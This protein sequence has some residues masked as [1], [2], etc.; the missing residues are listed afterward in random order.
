MNLKLYY[1]DEEIFNYNIVSDVID[2]SKL[3]I[4]NNKYIISSISKVSDL[5]SKLNSKYIITVTDKDN[6][7]LTDNDYLKTNC[8]I[9]I[10][11]SNTN[12]EYI[13]VVMGDV[14]GSGNIFIGDISKLY[15]YYKGLITLEES[16]KIAGDVTY[17]GVIE[18]N[19]ISK[20]Y[21]Y[22]KGIIKTLE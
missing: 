18:I 7:I 21:Q 13:I 6:N 15:R 12:Y 5:K 2:L 19:D 3:N 11:L 20:L 1:N 8:K 16:Y 10:K 4:K 9:S 17:D 14:T 22:Y